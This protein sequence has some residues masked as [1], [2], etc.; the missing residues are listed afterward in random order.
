MY[1]ASNAAKNCQGLEQRINGARIEAV[2]HDRKRELPLLLL[3]DEQEKMIDRYLERGDMFALRAGGRTLA[4]I[5]VTDEGEGTLEIKNLAVLP[6]VQG[7]GYGRAMIEFVA[8]HYRERFDT[9]LVGT[10]DSPLTLPFYERC[11][12]TR[13]YVVP[14]FFLRHYDHPIVEA[15]V[16]LR[17]M[18]YLKRRIE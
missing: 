12:F 16:R 2:G 8:V 10:G 13:A 11:G 18:V 5:V 7:R 17:D 3:G 6:E 15:G 4:V 1:S 14:D 9:L